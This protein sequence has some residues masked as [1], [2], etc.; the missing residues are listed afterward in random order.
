MASEINNADGLHA[1][2]TMLTICEYG[3]TSQRH[4]R[5]DFGKPVVRYHTGTHHAM[6][7]S[8]SLI[9]TGIRQQNNGE[10]FL[11]IASSYSLSICLW[12]TWQQP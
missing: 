6:K 7:A 4:P 10:D 5:G 11:R 1:A 9:L 2:T 12:Y 3:L 8:C